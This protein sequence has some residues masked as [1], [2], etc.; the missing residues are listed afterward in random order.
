M[1]TA[2][3]STYTN[4]ERRW[5]EICLGGRLHERWAERFG[6]LTMI[7]AQDGTTTLTGPVI[8][9][10]ALHGLL[11]QVRDLGLPLLLVRRLECRESGS[12]DAS[13]S[14]DARQTPSC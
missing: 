11:R 1:E 8:D 2:P 7:S 6:G 9:Q 13:V 3:S 14:E 12:A 5:Y 10:A 4:K